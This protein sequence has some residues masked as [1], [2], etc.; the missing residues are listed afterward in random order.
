MFEKK[1]SCGMLVA[2]R[3]CLGRSNG[4]WQLSHE[5]RASVY[6]DVKDVFRERERV[7]RL[8]VCDSFNSIL[9]TFDGKVFTEIQ[10]MAVVHL[11]EQISLVNGNRKLLLVPPRLIISHHLFPT[12]V[13]PFVSWIR[14][15]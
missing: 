11:S 8:I 4:D 10:D 9:L 13:L 5:Q 15:R 6:E 14:G 2:C 3:R 7:A 1:L 12:T